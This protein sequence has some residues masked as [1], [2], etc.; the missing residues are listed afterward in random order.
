MLEAAKQIAILL[1]HSHK[2]WLIPILLLL[3]ILALIII[4]A[5]I[6]PI[7]IFLYPII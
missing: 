4:G 2:I 7:P 6:A 1:T 3:I 5:Q